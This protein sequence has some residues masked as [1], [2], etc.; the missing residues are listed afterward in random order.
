MKRALDNNECESIIYY[1]R[2]NIFNNFYPNL[3]KPFSSIKTRE[4]WRGYAL[5]R[6]YPKLMFCLAIQRLKKVEAIWR[7]NGSPQWF[8]MQTYNPK[9]RKTTDSFA[10]DTLYKYDLFRRIGNL[11]ILAIED[12]APAQVMLAKLSSEE[13]HLRLT[14]AFA[15]FLTSRA[16]I[17]K[18]DDPDLAPLHKAAR[19]AL[20]EK[21]RAALDPLIKSGEWPQDWPLVRD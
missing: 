9:R 12:Y 13:R 5:P 20:S 1:L 15:Y 6:H 19:Q 21:A 11:I 17:N 3:P 18:L 10:D 8:L 7:A 2:E 14:P 4:A 16:T